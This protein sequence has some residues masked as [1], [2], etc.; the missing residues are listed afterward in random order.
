MAVAGVE[1]GSNSCD[2]DNEL[3]GEGNGSNNNTT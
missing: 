1:D 2:G 3:C